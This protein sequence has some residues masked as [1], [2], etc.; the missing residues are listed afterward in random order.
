MEVNRIRN[1]LVEETGDDISAVM[2]RN[3]GPLGSTQAWHLIQMEVGA[4]GTGG[5]SPRLSPQR[6]G[7]VRGEEEGSRVCQ[8][9]SPVAAAQQ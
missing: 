9:V 1:S 4:R 3:P 2:Q 6:R 7:G 5:A 8:A